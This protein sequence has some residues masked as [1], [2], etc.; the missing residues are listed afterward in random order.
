MLRTAFISAVSAL[1]ALVALVLIPTSAYA[2]DV[3]HAEL[4]DG[5]L[6]VD[7]TNA[8]PGV[9]VTV[10]SA[11]STA[12]SRSTVSGDYQVQASGFRAE[13]CMVVISDRETLTQTVRLSGCTPTAT[14]PPTPN[15][16]PTGSCL[17]NPGTPAGYP[18]GDL[19]TY[20]FTTKGCDTS[21]S[22]VQWSLLS[23]RIPVGMTG[24]T[25]QG[26]TAGEISGVPTLE[27]S[28]SFTVAVTD[29]TGATD[30]ET[31]SITVN[32]PR[33]VAVTTAT[34]PAGVHGRSYWV[35]LAADGGV[36]GYLWSLGSGTLPPGLQLTTWGALAGTPSTTGSYTFTVTATDSRGTTADQ[37]YT[38][39][40]G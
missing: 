11:T 36:P 6:R 38:L 40:I 7:G 24:P 30:T 37:T 3:T 5:Q 12:G 39:T 19:A 28:Y 21:T 1:I 8:T 9:F 33:P 17:I 26:Q 16:A 25:S 2:L 31:F 32:P 15:P 29:S 18:A 4:I 35:N 13:D 20:F 34:L 22:P 23:G 14:T 27:G 10:S